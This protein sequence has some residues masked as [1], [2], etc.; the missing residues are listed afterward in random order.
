M[1]IG[2]FVLFIYLVDKDERTAKCRRDLSDEKLSN[3]YGNIQCLETAGLIEHGEGDWLQSALFARYRVYAPVPDTS[4]EKIAPMLG[5]EENNPLLP[6]AIDAGKARDVFLEGM[7]QMTEPG[8][9]YHR[10]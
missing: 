1:G 8:E 9:F 3:L 5:I 2:I 6:L 7:G 4:I 10:K